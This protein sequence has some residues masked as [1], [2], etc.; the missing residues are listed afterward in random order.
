MVVPAT[1]YETAN[2][3]N[4]MS[5]YKRSGR[6]ANA[7][8]VAGLNLESLLGKAVEP[9][10]AL[11][12][13]S[14]LEHRFYQYANGYQAPFATI[15]GF[16]GGKIPSGQSI[17]AILLGLI[18]GTAVGV[19]STGDQPLNCPG[20]CRFGKKLKGFETGIILGLESKTSSPL[21]ALREP[22]RRCPGL[23]QP[24]YCR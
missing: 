8:C 23:F 4:G 13:L 14:D 17:P 21:Q 24:L 1:A 20:A 3:V 18:P 16:I 9:L 5:R 12:W 15:S 6:F 11:D 7:A 19:T 22:D 2:I 10:E